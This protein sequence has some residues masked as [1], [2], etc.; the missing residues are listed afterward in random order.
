VERTLIGDLDR[1]TERL[2]LD[3]AASALRDA[4]LRSYPGAGE[5]REVRILEGVT[6]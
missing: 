4:P 5:E 6:P 2:Y 1:E 3:A